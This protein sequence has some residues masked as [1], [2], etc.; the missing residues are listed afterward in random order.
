MGKILKTFVCFS[1]SPNFNRAEINS[2]H[3]V[4]NIPGKVQ[5]TRKFDIHKNNMQVQL[6]SQA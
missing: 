3:T 2:M 5:N 6:I 4:T 1:E